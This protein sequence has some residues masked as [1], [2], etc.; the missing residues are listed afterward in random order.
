ME[1]GSGVLD[2]EVPVDSGLSLVSFLFQNV[3][4][5]AEGLLVGDALFEAAAGEDTEFDLRHIQPASMLGGVVELQPPRY[6]PCLHRWKG[7]VQR[8][9][10]MGIEIVQNHP[11]H[12]HIG[13]GLVHQPTHLMGEVPGGAP[14]RYRH[15]PPASQGLDAKEQV[16]GATSGS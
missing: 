8:R 2:A 14:L 12:W 10:A 5:P 11:D 15:M 6:A 4:L 9:L 13:V 3:N 1:F 7:L 16:A